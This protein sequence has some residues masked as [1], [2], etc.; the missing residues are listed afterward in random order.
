MSDWI[1]WIDSFYADADAQL[2]ERVVDRFAPDG[3]MVFGN[4]PP[5][6]GRAAIR[7]VLTNLGVALAGMRHEWR[8]RWQADDQGTLLLEALVHYTTRGGT[9]LPLPCVTVIA[10][11]VSGL[12]TSLRIHIDAT[13]LFT[14]LSGEAA[15]A[16][17]G[18][19]QHM[20]G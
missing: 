12:V 1:D 16:P 19:P 13:L 7:E 4:N 17:A 5:A 8:N 9:E 11:A 3:E 20:A 15:T 6:I 10:R 18:S 2:V 14:A